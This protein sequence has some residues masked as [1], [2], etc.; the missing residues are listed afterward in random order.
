MFV[1]AL[2][3]IKKLGSR[4]GLCI[5]RLSRRKARMSAKLISGVLSRR[6]F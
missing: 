3:Q 1:G 5:Q 6:I 4:L 2:P